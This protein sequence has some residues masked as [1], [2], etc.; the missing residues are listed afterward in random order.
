MNLHLDRIVNAIRVAAPLMV[1]VPGGEKIAP[2]IPT[3]T[4]AMTDAAALKGASGA[5]KK[6][7]VLAIVDAGVVTA[8]ATG[9]VTLNPAEVQAIAS[10]AIDV[11]ASAAKA[12]EQA[13]AAG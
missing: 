5:E 10:Q 6:A 4:Q 8:N 2:L 9:H 7:R 11:V 13:H 3:I 1:L 12:V